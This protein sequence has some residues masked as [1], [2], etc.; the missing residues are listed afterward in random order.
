[1][2]A[3]AFEIEDAAVLV[4]GRPILDELRLTVPDRAVTVV[5][6]PG[7]TGKSSLLLALS[8][9]AL[10]EGMT[11]EG[12]WRYRGRPLPPL[13][14]AQISLWRQRRRGA[15]GLSWRDAAWDQAD[16]VLLDEPE[17]R[18]DSDADRAALIERLEAQRARGA[19]VVVTHDLTLARRIADRVVLLCAGRV[20][21]AGPG[22]A[23]FESPPTELARRFITQ[24]NCWPRFAL[25]SHFHWVRDGLAG[26]GRPGL[27]GD[28]DTDL[29]AIASAGIE[30]LVSLTEQPVAPALLRPYGIAS[31]HF[32]VA[33][34]GVP[35]V[36]S[37]V[38][39][40]REISR[41][42]DGGGGVA[43]HCHAGV[44]RTGTILAAYLV[45]IGVSADDAVAEVRRAIRGA[46]Q[47]R[48]Q[49]QFVYR[50]AETYG[51][52]S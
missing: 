15:P 27:L 14:P 35:Q 52:H 51:G 8:G 11:T 29:A 40:C 3:P 20:E 42:R 21:A 41:I 39:L 10:P 36:S 49:L 32:P 45:T 22:R 13:D 47:S 44:G 46:I 6:G 9:R 18:L 48:A 28:V 34:M 25:P 43:V 23:F 4:P 24:G 2:T 31:R 50:F 7:G 12:R 1:M 5:L 30:Q 33:D 26:M 38:G 19:A 16:T 17:S 37:T